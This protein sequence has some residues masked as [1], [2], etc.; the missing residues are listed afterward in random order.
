MLSCRHC[1]QQH[2]NMQAPGSLSDGEYRRRHFKH[3]L[4]HTVR[5]TAHMQKNP[6]NAAAQLQQSCWNSMPATQGPP[7]L[8]RRY[9]NTAAHQPFWPKGW[10]VNR[11]RACCG[12]LDSM[13]G[14][15]DC[16]PVGNSSSCDHIATDEGLN[17]AHEKP[18]CCS[19][20]RCQR[21][22]REVCCDAL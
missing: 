6:D 15:T 16:L 21:V 4:P 12:A 22:W 11:L 20:T 5:L 13:V 19:S 9:N 7:P 10:F 8:P 17:S 18:R 14:R 2:T 3:G 1:M